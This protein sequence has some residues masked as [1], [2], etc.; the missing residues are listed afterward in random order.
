MA[1]LFR[2]WFEQSPMLRIK[3]GGARLLNRKTRNP[4]DFIPPRIGLSCDV[5]SVR[6]VE[7]YVDTACAGG[8]TLTRTSRSRLK[9]EET[10]AFRPEFL[11]YP[12]FSRLPVTQNLRSPHVSSGENI[13]AAFIFN[14]TCTP[15]T[16]VYKLRLSSEIEEN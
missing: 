2:V 13:T 15:R 6:P 7:P 12:L 16:V 4:A 1:R 8:Y 14:V 9:H 11:L 10:R 5:E 3:S